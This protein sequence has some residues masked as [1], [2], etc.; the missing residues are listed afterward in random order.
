VE[1]ARRVGLPLVVAAKTDPT[2]RDY[3]ER[4][5]RP[6]LDGPGVT[7]VGEVDEAGK[8]EVLGRAAALL[9]PIDWPEPFGLVMIEAMACGTPVVAFAG[10]SV[11]EVLDD[12]V[13]GYVVTDLDQAVA[14]TRAAL[15]LDRD[16]IR[17]T[18]ERRFSVRR[19]AE[20]YLAAYRRLVQ[21]RRPPARSPA[22]V[23]GGRRP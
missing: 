5:V 1:I 11:R 2:E 15:G 7:H 17:A 18:F 6:L 9:F 16:R 12:G 23:A 4:E 14:A 3:F 13:T 22:R 19:M 21:G 20:D 10:G 8:A